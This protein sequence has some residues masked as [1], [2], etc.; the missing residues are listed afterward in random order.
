MENETVQFKAFNFDASI[1]AGCYVDLS[2][3]T[4][5]QIAAQENLVIIPES[6]KEN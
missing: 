6:I 4:P 3:L 2:Q 1:V 5:Q